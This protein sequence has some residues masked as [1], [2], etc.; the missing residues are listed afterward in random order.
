MI[1]WKGLSRL[2]GGRIIC[3]VTGERGERK[4]KN[5]KTGPVAQ[6][7]VLTEETHPVEAKEN[8]EDV[9]ICG[10]CPLR[11]ECYVALVNDGVCATWT[12]Y[13]RGNHKPYDSARLAKKKV[14]LGSYGDF[15]NLPI[16][17]VKMIVDD[18]DGHTGFTHQWKRQDCQHLREYCMASVGSVAELFQAWL[19]GWRTFRT[20]QPGEPVLPGEIVCPGSKEAGKRKQCIDCGA[21]NGSR[22]TNDRRVSVVTDLH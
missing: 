8:G 22:G 15:A 7:Y 18:S 11:K 19:M 12:K 17:M 16:E 1:L 4:S 9:H 5:V 13:H 6:T 2:T 10:D 21:C 20:K 14:R 3:L